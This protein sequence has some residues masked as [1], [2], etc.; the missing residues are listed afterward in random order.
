LI[1]CA[2][3]VGLPLREHVEAG[4]VVIQWQPTLRYGLDALAEHILDDVR[5]RNVRRVVFDGI[6]GFRQASA[7][8]PERTIRF[9]TALTNQ[10]RVLDVTVMITEETQKIFG[11]DVE[12][13]I[14]GLSALVDNIVLLEYLD[15]GGELKRLL[16]VVKQRGSGH[17]GNVR[18][19]RIGPGGIGLAADPSSAA[20]ILNSAFGEGT[21]RTRRPRGT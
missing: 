9:L 7:G 17:D 5:R 4:R 2:E 8:A 18:E 11:P 20:A 10:L 1:E 6:D 15:V 14:P 16:S 21:V 3:S 12:V 13:R 19:L